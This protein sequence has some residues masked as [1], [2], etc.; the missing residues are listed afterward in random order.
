MSN[1]GLGQK[2]RM[3]LGK[4]HFVGRGTYNHPG[5]ASRWS[6]ERGSVQAVPT[7]SVWRNT[8]GTPTAASGLSSFQSCQ[9][10]CRRAG[11]QL[12][13]ATPRA[14]LTNANVVGLSP[15]LRQAVAED[16]ESAKFRQAQPDS[17]AGA[18]A[19]PAAQSPLAAAASADPIILASCAE[20]HH[21]TRASSCGGGICC[22]QHAAAR[23]RLWLV[24]WG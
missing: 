4:P 14:S 16:V 21:M 15:R 11:V 2:L 22:A 6:H 1:P 20:N 7:C 9:S 18:K 23:T 12:F 3:E 8:C 24:D 17:P 19:E 13:S 5:A 10:Y